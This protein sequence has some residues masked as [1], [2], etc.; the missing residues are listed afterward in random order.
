MNG[1]HVFDLLKQSE[2]E[3]NFIYEIERGWRIH[4]LPGM[5]GLWVHVEKAAARGVQAQGLWHEDIGGNAALE[6]VQ[7]GASQVGDAS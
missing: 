7:V 6:G 4:R 5:F 2:T 1:V 3:R